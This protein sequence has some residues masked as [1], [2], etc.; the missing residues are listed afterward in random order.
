MIEP[1]G[2]QRIRPWPTSSSMWKSFSSLPSLRWSRALACSSALEVLGEFL[3]GGEGGAVDAL[4]LLVLF[5]AAVIGAGDGEE[6]EG[7]QLRGVAHVRAGAEVHELAVLVEGDFLA[8]GDVGEA[9]ELVALLAALRD[10]GDGLL[11]GDFLAQ[12]GLVLVGDLLHL[13]L[14]LHEVVG[15]QFVLQI[16]VVVEP[17]V[18]RRTDVELRLGK[19]AKDGGREDVRAGVAEFFER[20]HR[21]G[22]GFLKRGV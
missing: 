18:G 20:C 2:V 8:L 14:E 15:G 4:E 12:E 9:A 10:D 22:S 3:L 5:V 21:H 19:E 6:L 11:A 17:G 1:L 13:G 16:D 7:L